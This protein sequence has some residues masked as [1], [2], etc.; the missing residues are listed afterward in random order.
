MNKKKKTNRLVAILLSVLLVLGVSSFAYANEATQGVAE[1]SYT[2]STGEGKEATVEPSESREEES[3]EFVAR[4][5]EGLENDASG[6]EPEEAIDVDQNGVTGEEDAVIVYAA[7]DEYIVTFDPDDGTP[8]PTW[9]KT[10]VP[11]GGLVTS[12]PVDPQQDGYIFKGWYHSL[13][14][15]GDPVFWEFATDTV[16]DNTTLW[17]AWEV[18]HIV[19]FDPD[20][21]TPYPTWFKTTVPDGGLVTSRP[22]DPQR[23]GYVFAG[24]YHSLDGSGDPI[25]WDFASHTV[26]ANT[27]LWAAWAE[28]PIAHLTYTVQFDSRGGS[29]VNAVTGIEEGSTITSPPQ[30]TREGYV[31]T[32]WFVD[33]TVTQKWNFAVDEV[34]SDLTLYAGWTTVGNGNNENS[35][36][37]ENN[38]EKESSGTNTTS[39]VK[40]PKT[41]DSALDTGLYILLAV[42]AGAGVVTL[43]ARKLKKEKQNK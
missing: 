41:G 20:D 29:A 11:D 6:L 21:G 34:N 23:E 9:F 19:T 43:L 8:Y 32:G 15:N 10:T 5:N 2:E 18:G 38:G 25:F 22:A 35:G 14:G 26:T 39:E 7:G 36:S 31:F 24:W 28:A 42:A 17:A 13:D 27:T 16:T 1:T 12:R 30:P 3:Q 33:E 37:N 40:P 4:E